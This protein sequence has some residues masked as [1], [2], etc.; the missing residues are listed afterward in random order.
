MI[1]G[2]TRGKL[3]E[4]DLH[5][6]TGTLGGYKQAFGFSTYDGLGRVIG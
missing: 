5:A 3:I 1:N 2:A 4:G 6:K